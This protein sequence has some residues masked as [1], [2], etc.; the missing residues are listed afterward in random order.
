MDTLDAARATK[1]DKKT[2]SIARG[3]TADLFVVDGDPLARI[4]DVR[5]VVST[6]R[7]GVLYASTPLFESVGVA[8]PN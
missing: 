5:K 3:K 4:A 8:P 7:A 2:G 6:M 1:L